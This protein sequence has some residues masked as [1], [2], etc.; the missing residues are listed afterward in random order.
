MHFFFS[1]KARFLSALDVI[2]R[3]PQSEMRGFA[4]PART[5]LESGTFASPLQVVAQRT[6]LQSVPAERRWSAS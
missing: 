6:D 3:G 2:A 4:E 1:F 5:V